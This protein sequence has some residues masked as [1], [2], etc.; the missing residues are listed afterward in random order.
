M[1]N[2]LKVLS[3]AAST[4]FGLQIAQKL[5]SDGHHVFASTRVVKDKNADAV[6]QAFLTDIGLGSWNKK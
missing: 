4:G 5:A 2:S 3:T 1:N 6:Q